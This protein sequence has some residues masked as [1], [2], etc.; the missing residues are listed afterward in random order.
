MTTTKILVRQNDIVYV[1]MDGVLVESRESKEEW[2]VG[3]LKQEFFLNKEPVFG[4]VEAFRLL[5]S[6]CNTCKSSA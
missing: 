5:S 1:D 6:K 2:E 3:R 4:A